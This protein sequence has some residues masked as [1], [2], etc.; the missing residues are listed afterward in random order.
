MPAFVESHAPL[1]GG[2]LVAV[3]SSNKLSA[4][5]R[6]DPE[7]NMLVPDC[8]FQVEVNRGADI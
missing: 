4:V 7:R 2:E 5:Y 8:V 3:V 6:Y 1:E